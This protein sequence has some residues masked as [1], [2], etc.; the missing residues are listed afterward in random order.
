MVCKFDVFFKSLNVVLQLGGCG[1]CSAD[2]CNF[3]AETVILNNVL[4]YDS[5]VYTGR[6]SNWSIWFIHFFLS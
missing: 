3:K 6:W 5:E 2:I 1:K 4:W